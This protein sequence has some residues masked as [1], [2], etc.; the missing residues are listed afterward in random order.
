MSLRWSS[1]SHDPPGDPVSAK[2]GVCRVGVAKFEFPRPPPPP[3]ATTNRC[4]SSRR[5]A[6]IVPSPMSVTCV[7]TGTESTM[8]SPSAPCFRV[9]RPLPPRFASKTVL[10]RNEER[11]RRSASA[12]ST[13]SPPR[14]PSPPSGP[15]L[16]T[17]FSRRKLRPPSPPRPALTRIRTRS[18]KSDPRLR[19]GSTL[20]VASSVMSDH[21]G[22]F[23][24][25]ETA[26]SATPHERPI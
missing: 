9:P 2:R 14:P 13:T 15:P 24:G 21:H 17:N 12:T 25:G 7:P 1:S 10:A 16:G 11:S 3:R 22:V 5:S 23:P 19:R 26:V 18:W 8:S 4:S 20:D 6:T